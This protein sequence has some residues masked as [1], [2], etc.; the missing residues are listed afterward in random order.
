MHW[1]VEPKEGYKPMLSSQSLKVR[2]CRVP[3]VSVSLR[4]QQGIVSSIEDGLRLS[5]R[6]HFA[7]PRRF[8]RLEVLQQPITFAL[9]RSDVLR[10]RHE[11]VGRRVFAILGCLEVPLQVGLRSRLVGDRV[12]VRG[13]FC[14]GISHCTFIVGL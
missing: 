4:L 11:L 1:F 9:E 3:Q 5:E 14:G 12:R 7:S 6:V 2:L 8:P 10:A 13:A